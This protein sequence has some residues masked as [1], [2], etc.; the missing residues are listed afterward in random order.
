MS[1]II[2]TLA[3]ATIVYFVLEF[4]LNMPDMIRNIIILAFSILYHSSSGKE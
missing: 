2:V 4:L 1:K 3:L